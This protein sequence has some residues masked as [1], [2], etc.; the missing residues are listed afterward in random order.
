MKILA[1]DIE[2]KA[3][4]GYFYQ[5]YKP[6]IGADQIIEP[7][8]MI[9]FSAQWQNSKKVIFYSEHHNT[10]KEMLDELHALLDE[11]DAIVT[12]NGKRFDLPWIYG[13]LLVEGY[14]PPSPVKHI[15]L[16]QILKSNS[17]FISGK[18]D[19]AVQRLVGDRKVEGMNFAMW[20]KCYEGDEKAWS[21]VR[22][23]AKKDTELLW[24]LYNVLRPW[25]KDHPNVAL[26]DGNSAGCPNCGGTNLQRRGYSYTGVG[27]YRK[28]QCQTCGKWSKGSQNLGLTE[29]RHA[30]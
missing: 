15:D 17:R 14:L 23:Y 7:P 28:Y 26:H 27:K 9:A 24:P 8:R 4:I 3:A 21:L 12:F 1:L 6:V 30:T 13:E 18:L 19:Y 22:R 10:R 20:R 11:A 25:I 5:A 2:T 16:Y 29:F